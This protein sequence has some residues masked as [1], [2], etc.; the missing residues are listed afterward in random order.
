MLKNNMNPFLTHVE[1]RLW[2]KKSIHLTIQKNFS[3]N[4]LFGLQGILHMTQKWV[5]VIPTRYYTLLT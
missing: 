4:T 5:H 3:M 1:D 2:T